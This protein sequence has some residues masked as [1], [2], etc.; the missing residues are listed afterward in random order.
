LADAIAQQHSAERIRFFYAVECLH[1]KGM[2]GRVG[3]TIRDSVLPDNHDRRPILL[4]NPQGR[5][6]LHGMKM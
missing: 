5:G 4:R 6:H 2:I 3:Y 1:V